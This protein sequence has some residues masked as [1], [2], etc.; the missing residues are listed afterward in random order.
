MDTGI[1]TGYR[2]RPPPEFS[3]FPDRFL[4]KIQLGDSHFFAV[5]TQLQG[6]I[7]EFG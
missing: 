6:I 4:G 2:L 5:L 7:F 1:S 3:S